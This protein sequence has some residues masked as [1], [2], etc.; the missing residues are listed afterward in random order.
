MEYYLWDKYRVD[1]HFYC[2]VHFWIPLVHVY[3][4]ADVEIDLELFSINYLSGSLLW[5]A[6]NFE[7]LIIM[8]HSES[9]QFI[10]E[11]PFMTFYWSNIH[12][13]IL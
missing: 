4:F 5:M 2:S 13:C 11:A 8:E 1:P 10:S 9:E 12:V 6:L 7:V 3:W